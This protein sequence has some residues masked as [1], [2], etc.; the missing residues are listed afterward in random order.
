MRQSPHP[1]PETESISINC[2][3][4]VHEGK[5]APSHKLLFCK[6]R[7]SQEQEKKES[8]QSLSCSTLNLD[9]EFESLNAALSSCSWT[10][11]SKAMYVY[12]SMEM[13]KHSD[14]GTAETETKKVTKT[15]RLQGREVYAFPVSCSY[16]L[17]GPNL[18]LGLAHMNMK[19]N[20]RCCCADDLMQSSQDNHVHVQ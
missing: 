1:P 20:L 7:G 16:V 10:S 9:L 14:S 5:E 2:V 6:E 13:E 8:F 11:K 3:N 12:G 18:H 19:V 15:F 4:F 17:F